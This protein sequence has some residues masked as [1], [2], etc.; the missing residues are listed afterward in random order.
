MRPITNIGGELTSKGKVRTVPDS[1]FPAIVRFDVFEIDL[2]AGELRKEGRKSRYKNNPFVFCL[3]CCSGRRKWSH[4]K[5]C[6]NNF[7]P[8]TR[9][10]ILITD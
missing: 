9:L 5:N 1:Q 8:P 6:G 10:W 7:G 2:Q 4:A 3:C